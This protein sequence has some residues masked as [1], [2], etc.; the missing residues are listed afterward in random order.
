M[1]T[2]LTPHSVTFHRI[3]SRRRGSAGSSTSAA[4]TSASASWTEFTPFE[5]PEET[6]QFDY[7][8]YALGAGLPDPVNVWKPAY[9]TATPEDSELSPGSKRCGV[10]FMEK[11]ASQ[12]KK[13]DRILIVGGG[14]LGIRTYCQLCRGLRT[15]CQ[16][17]LPISR[18]YIPINMSPYFILVCV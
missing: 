2:S 8:L 16:N 4:S 11:Q 3:P 12:M 1:I 10:R 6:I 18:R 13:A 5:G 14:A 15:N 17:T 9:G 7:A